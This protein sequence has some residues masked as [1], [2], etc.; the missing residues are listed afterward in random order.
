MLFIVVIDFT[1]L[2]VNLIISLVC[3]GRLT[4]IQSRIHD[5]LSNNGSFVEKLTA[6]VF[7]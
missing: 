4:K 3:A 1:L 7:T 6:T 5:A 2:I